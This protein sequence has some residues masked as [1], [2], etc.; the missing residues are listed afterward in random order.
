MRTLSDQAPDFAPEEFLLAVKR[1]VSAT[2][3]PTRGHEALLWKVGVISLWFTASY[4]G[5]LSVGPVL[6][7][8]ALCFSYALAASAVGFNIFHDANHGAVFSS[9]RANLTLSI[10]V[11]CVLGPSRYFWN[12]KHQ[13]LHHR[14]TNIYKWDDDLETRGYL[15][16]SP[17]QPWQWRFTGQHRYFLLLYAVNALEWFFI[18]DFVQ[19]FTLRIN[20]FRSIPPMSAAEHAEFWLCKIVYFS[21]FVAPPF[22]LLPAI[23]AVVGLLVFYLTLGLVVALVFNLAHE[24]EAVSFNVS[25][26]CSPSIAE[27]WGSLQMK[28]TSNFATSHP[29]WN[30]FTGGLNHQIEH[31]LFPGTRHTDYPQI[32][33]IVRQT[34]EQFGLPYIC[35]DTYGGALR[36]HYRLLKRL[37]ARPKLEAPAV[38]PIVLQSARLRAGHAVHASR[39]HVE[40]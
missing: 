28:S 5:A 2:L 8:L 38:D 40:T 11:S 3:A 35:F 17:D 4:L 15:R 1:R 25:G 7:K 36:S 18:K 23:Q 29:V 27:S 31:H 13:T 6:L 20:N 14:Y 24:V 10:A 16:M 19:Y 34:A 22:L 32:G 33:A 26:A 9:R 12:F 39:V 30:W 37:S 21:L